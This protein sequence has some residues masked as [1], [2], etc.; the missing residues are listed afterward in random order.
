MA[1][2]GAGAGFRAGARRFF[3][4]GFAASAPP[5]KCVA[6]AKHAAVVSP[7]HV[8][9]IR[10]IAAT[11]HL[12]HIITTLLPH[13]TPDTAMRYVRCPSNP[14]H[15]HGIPRHPSTRAHPCQVLAHT[16]C[17]THRSPIRRHR[18][19]LRPSNSPPPRQEG[20][21]H[22]L[23]RRPFSGLLLHPLPCPPIRSF[24]PPAV[25]QRRVVVVVVAS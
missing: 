1:G 13:W 7:H 19:R 21:I 20:L 25:F 4:F 14:T 8:K 22:S 11:L 23:S 24:F 17:A 10:H 9:Q 18:H 12:I 16:R 2:A 5:S 15:P 6:D 3:T